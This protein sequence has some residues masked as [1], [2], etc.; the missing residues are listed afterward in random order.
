M[1]PQPAATVMKH[2]LIKSVDLFKAVHL[3]G[4]RRRQRIVGGL[5]HNE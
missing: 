3:G 5:F 4:R 2:L 1:A